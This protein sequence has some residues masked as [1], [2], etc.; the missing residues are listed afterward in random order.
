[1][2]NEF[3]TSLARRWR[4]AASRRGAEIAEPALDPMVA[5]ELLQLA[6][7]AAHT[8][9]RRFAPLATYT[10][11]IAAERLRVAR[12]ADAGAIAAFIREVREEL[13]KEGEPP[14]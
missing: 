9:E 3:F 13:E 11:G 4:E 6:S 5:D 14:S 2:M 1:M 8:K 7:T 10:A 12:G